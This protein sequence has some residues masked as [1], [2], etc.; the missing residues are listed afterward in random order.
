MQRCVVRKLA[1]SC[2][3][4]VHM[5]CCKQDALHL[6]RGHIHAEV[7]LVRIAGAAWH[8]G[9]GFVTHAPMHVSPCMT[10][11]HGRA[12]CAQHRGSRAWPRASVVCTLLFTNRPMAWPAGPPGPLR[13]AAASELNSNR[14]AA[15][16]LYA[17]WTRLLTL[18]TVR[19]SAGS[20][21]R[22]SGAEERGWWCF[23]LAPTRNAPR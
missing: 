14:A 3:I 15:G 22:S 9:T 8:A 11:S 20:P 23:C 21:L 13:P 5:L 12:T 7:S 18:V 10:A 1:L 6:A 4:D 2:T 19:A 16:A 17:S